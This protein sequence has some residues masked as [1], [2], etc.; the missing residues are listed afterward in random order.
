MVVA[1]RGRVSCEDDSRQGVVPVKLLG[2]M[3]S[4]MA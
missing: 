3:V 1:A 4:V 2:D